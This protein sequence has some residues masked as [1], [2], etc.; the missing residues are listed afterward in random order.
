MS[1]TVPA[2]G[3]GGVVVG[4]NA[5]GAVRSRVRGSGISGICG[6]LLAVVTAGALV[7]V[8]VRM[9]RIQVG[10]DLARG[11]QTN[12]ELLEQQRRL[13]IEIGMLKDPVRV[14]MLARY[15]LGMAPPTPA[16]LRILG[17]ADARDPVASPRGNAISSKAIFTS[18]GA[19]PSARE[20]KR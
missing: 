11:R 5:P 13:Q 1:G 15:K 16:A 6:I 20:E 17:G 4:A 7:H 18:A 14:V 19:P 8:G 10:Y 9:T 2:R 3:P 12:Q